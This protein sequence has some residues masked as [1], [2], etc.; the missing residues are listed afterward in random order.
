MNRLFP[1][2]F[3][4]T[5]ALV[6]PSPALADPIG[7]VIII[8]G[9]GTDLDP[10]RLRTSTGCP[11]KASAYYAT[12]RVQGFPPDGQ[13]VTANTE[14]GLSTSTGFDVYVALIMRDYAE[15]NHTTLAGRYDITVHCTDG[16]ALESYGEFTGS[17]KFTSPTTY[18]AIGA[19]K[20]PASPPPPWPMAGDNYAL[21]EDPASDNY[22][23]A[24][25]PASPSTAAAPATGRPEPSP[26]A[27]VPIGQTPETDAQIP[28]PAGQRASQ[29]N[30]VT[31]QGIPWLAL[32]LV[33]LVLVALVAAVVAKQIRKHHLS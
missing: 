22:A 11:T 10:I 32:V 16:L 18:Q 4:V 1:V 19:A 26:A 30:E 2:A 5:V 25:D 12:M 27:Q 13:I 17:L 29:R 6:A 20:P 24:E 23:P 15:E 31:V 14:A 28:L 3:L 8:P 7:G 21:A 9:T 33:S